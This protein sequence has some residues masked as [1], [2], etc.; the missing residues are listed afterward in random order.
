MF[1]ETNFF[2]TLVGLVVL[3][4]RHT[5]LQDETIW[6]LSSQNRMNL[7]RAKFIVTLLRDNVQE[8]IISE[9]TPKVIII[10]IIANLELSVKNVLFFSLKI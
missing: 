9:A 8:T 7:C 4:H 1:W 10:I 6:K 3:H 5:T 2:M